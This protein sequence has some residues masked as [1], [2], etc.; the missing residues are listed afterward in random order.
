[1]KPPKQKPSNIVA[2]QSL[3]NGKLG[4]PPAASHAG[5]ALCFQKS[6][7]APFHKLWTALCPVPCAGGWQCEHKQHVALALKGAGSGQEILHS[8][9]HDSA[10]YGG[11]LMFLWPLWTTA[12][13]GGLM[14]SRPLPVT[15]L[16]S[17]GLSG[18]GHPSLSSSVLCALPL[19]PSHMPT[20]LPLVLSHLCFQLTP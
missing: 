16:C 18:A 1:M 8:Q 5:V 6:F 10:A 4:N 9:S 14:L 15:P 3:P 7:T 12:S 19:P 20:S 17:P 13:D 11:S 2:P